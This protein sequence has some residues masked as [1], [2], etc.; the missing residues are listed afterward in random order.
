MYFKFK[1]KP[2]QFARWQFELKQLELVDV[3][4]VDVVVV[5]VVVEVALVGRSSADLR[6]SWPLAEG[7]HQIEDRLEGSDVEVM[8]SGIYFY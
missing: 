1:K 4:V 7:R 8:K 5:A 6:R 2:E 3:A